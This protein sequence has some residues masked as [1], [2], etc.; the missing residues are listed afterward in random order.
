[1]CGLRLVQ[2]HHLLA[3]L[4]PKTIWMLDRNFAQFE[5]TFEV[6]INSRW[7]IPKTKSKWSF[8]RADRGSDKDFCHEL[9]LSF[10]IKFSLRNIWQKQT[11]AL[12]S[13]KRAIEQSDSGTF[14]FWRGIF[15]SFVFW[16]NSSGGQLENEMVVCRWVAQEENPLLLADTQI[17]CG[18]SFQNRWRAQ[19]SLQPVHIDP[20]VGC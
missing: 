15:Y 7:L 18:C 8:S 1:M 19:K 3:K 10:F 11:W 5:Q 13:S 2:K 16:T 12:F 4:F 6:W 17:A 14:P 20:P 9:S